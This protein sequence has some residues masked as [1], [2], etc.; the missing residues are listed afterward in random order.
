MRGGEGLTV[1]VRQLAEPRQQGAHSSAVACETLWPRPARR[2]AN[3]DI[4]DAHIALFTAL[5][6]MC[7]LHQLLAK[8]VLVAM[9]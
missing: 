2:C 5:V 3:G 4:S 7:H 1:S 9:D 6:S 8:P